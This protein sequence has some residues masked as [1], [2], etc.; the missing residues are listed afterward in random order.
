MKKLLAFSGKLGSGKDYM[1]SQMMRNM[2]DNGRTI[3]WVSFADPIKR[4]LRDCFS[5][6]KSGK[7]EPTEDCCDHEITREYVRDCIVDRIYH[8][9]LWNGYQHVNKSMVEANYNI[10]GEVFYEYVVKA[11]NNDDYAF[12]YRRLGQ[13]LGTEL[14]RHVVDTIW[15]DTAF[16][17]IT[18][19]F[20]QDEADV[21]FI[22]D[23]RFV[24]EY[25]AVQKFE[26]MTVYKTECYG[27]VASDETRAKRRGLTMD[28]IK[29]QDNHGSEAELDLIIER[30]DPKFIIHND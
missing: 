12:S 24:N 23:C 17:K 2:K 25:E 19:V 13:L 30:L 26:R 29:A 27:V 9:C 8:L 3:Y 21:A 7:I 28:E 18:Q 1:A 22:T 6:D 11:V 4:I 10:H 20:Q 5:L 15:I 14:A 16:M